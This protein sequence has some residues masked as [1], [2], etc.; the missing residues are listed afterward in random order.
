MITRESFYEVLALVDNEFNGDYV[1]GVDTSA[2][3]L[4]LTNVREFPI[5][6]LVTSD[7]ASEFSNPNVEV[8]DTLDQLPSKVVQVNGYNC[9]SVERTLIDLL[10]YERN[11]Q[12]IVESLAYY[13][14]TIQDESWGTLPQLMNQ[15]DLTDEFES[16]MEDAQ[17]YY[18]N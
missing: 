10:Y 7:I 11:P 5:T 8:V 2:R 17:D 6:I 1:I 18:D 9:T 12:V 16:Y 14:Y 3:L 15:H 4:G 13:Y